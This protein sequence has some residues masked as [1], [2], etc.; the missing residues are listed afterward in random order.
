MKKYIGYF[1]VIVLCGFA[2]GM[3]NKQH[4]FEVVP[5]NYNEYIVKCNA[6][7]IE[8]WQDNMPMFSSSD[9]ADVIEFIMQDY[10][11]LGVWL[12]KGLCMQYEAD[13]LNAKKVIYQLIEGADCSEF[14]GE[15]LIEFY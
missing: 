15:N 2:Y 8:V 5:N 11:G 13:S 4:T 1:I 3:L 6:F 10:D 7:N 9:T 12:Y 14:E